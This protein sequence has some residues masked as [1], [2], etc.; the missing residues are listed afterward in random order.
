M[1]MGTVGTQSHDVKSKEGEEL[2]AVGLFPPSFSPPFQK[3]L[4]HLFLVHLL[5]GRRILASLCHLKGDR[6]RNTDYSFSW[7]REKKKK[8]RF[9]F[10][11]WIFCLDLSCERLYM[12]IQVF[13]KAAVTCFA[14]TSRCVRRI[15]VLPRK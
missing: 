6:L 1:V 11:P 7:R 15:A 10:V 8:S 3:T 12:W 13:F 2:M 5:S 4:L 14:R 9:Q